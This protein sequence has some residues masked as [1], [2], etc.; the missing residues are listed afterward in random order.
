MAQVRQILRSTISKPKKM[1]RLKGSS[2]TTSGV[3]KEFFNTKQLVLMKHIKWCRGTV[4][5]LPHL[6]H[7][8]IMSVS[9]RN[10][11]QWYQEFL[12]GINWQLNSIFTVLLNYIRLQFHTLIL[13]FCLFQSQDLPVANCSYTVMWINKHQTLPANF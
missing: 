11:K 1:S 9:S 3:K 6:K 8:H 4:I 2:M 7:Q 13:K 10:M 5:M 12:L